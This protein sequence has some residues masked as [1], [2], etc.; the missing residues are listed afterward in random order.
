MN[1]YYPN[2]FIGYKISQWILLNECSHRQRQT[3]RP[4]DGQ[5]A[6]DQLSI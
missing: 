1:K 4:M 2:C 6:L 3:E 5:T